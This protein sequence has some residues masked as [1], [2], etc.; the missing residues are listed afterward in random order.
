M[1]DSE[2]YMPDHESC[3]CQQSECGKMACQYADVCVPIELKPNAT[4][5]KVETECCGDPYV[6]CRQKSGNMC[7]ILI[8]QRVEI[9]IPVTYSVIACIGEN[10]IDCDCDCKED[11]H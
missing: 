7:E 11:E 3:D 4:I 2:R 8:K 1:N 6:L 10:M 9:R 5:G